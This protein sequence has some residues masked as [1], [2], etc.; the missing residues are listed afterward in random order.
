MSIDVFPQNVRSE[1]SAGLF[2]PPDEI[3]D[4][5]KSE[6]VKQLMKDKKVFAAV[7][8]NLKN[9]KE[10]TAA[11]SIRLSAATN[12]CVELDNA[13]YQLMKAL[14]SPGATEIL[15]KNVIRAKFTA[16]LFA[17][18][19]RNCHGSEFEPAEK[20]LARFGQ[21]DED[22]ELLKDDW[23]VP[24][25]GSLHDDLRINFVAKAAKKKSMEDIFPVIDDILSAIILQIGR[26]GI[27]GYS[28][29]AEVPIFLHLYDK[30]QSVCE[31]AVT[32]MLCCMFDKKY[33]DTAST[34]YEFDRVARDMVDV[35][36]FHSSLVSNYLGAPENEGL[37]ADLSR[38][39]ALGIYW[40]P[41]EGVRTPV[42][43]RMKDPDKA[44]PG[45]TITWDM[46]C[47]GTTDDLIIIESRPETHSYSD[48]MLE[49]ELG[50]S[51]D[52][53]ALREA[54]CM[55][56]A[57]D[58]ERYEYY[59]KKKTVIINEKARKRAEKS[60][61]KSVS[62]DESLAKKLSA[63]TTELAD[64]RAKN[65]ELVK[66]I[67]ELQTKLFH[68]ENKEEQLNQL[69][70][71]L[72]AVQ[73]EN[74][75]QKYQIE[76][77]EQE[78]DALTDQ[79]DKPDKEP[80]DQEQINTSPLDQVNI[81]CFGGHP[82][83]AAAMKDF[84]KNVRLYPNGGPMPEDAI[85]SA[86]IVWLQVNSMSHKDFYRLINRA[87]ALGKPVKYFTCAGHRSSKRQLVSE[88]QEYLTAK[89]AE[90]DPNTIV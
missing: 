64:Q 36:T 38:N 10:F 46:Y 66:Q 58:R 62:S 12:A 60:K 44:M 90:A 71:E 72:S 2:L 51:V 82:T 16:Y 42:D 23:I 89:R 57:L 70:S 76:A 49:A 41:N 8:Q 11:F 33:A 40:G 39:S 50:F 53:Y 54:A 4:E 59:E 3:A 1:S 61:S 67:R 81:V 29:F 69:N 77:L 48:E 22:E 65:A 31:A 27:L 85:D 78:I 20:I 74:S 30:D 6:M 7:S 45:V 79:I 86:D 84:H 25:S 26:N 47:A 43:T 5:K 13:K 83:W 56:T 34:E 19:I 37:N 75:N 18:L 28:Y 24:L 80:P 35:H 15:K 88:T 21:F 55:A 87:R 14:R 63:A 68:L 73:N 17:S 9:R 32:K 52:R